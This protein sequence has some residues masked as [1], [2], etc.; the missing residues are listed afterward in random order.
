MRSIF[1]FLPVGETLVVDRLGS[2]GLFFWPG[3]HS[4]TV[5]ADAGAT[6]TAHMAMAATRA[7]RMDLRTGSPLPQGG[8]SPTS[9]RDATDRLDVSLNCSRRLPVGIEHADHAVEAARS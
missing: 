7:A 1:S 6:A 3:L 9:L 8:S 5:L 2:H 4:Q